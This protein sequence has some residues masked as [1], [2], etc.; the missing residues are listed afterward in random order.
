MHNTYVYTYC[1]P[2]LLNSINKML[3]LE[4][5]MDKYKYCYA[6]SYYTRFKISRYT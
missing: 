4:D 1:E 3:K 5:L 6:M 2:K